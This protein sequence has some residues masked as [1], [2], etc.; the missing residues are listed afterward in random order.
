L[1]ARTS[2]VPKNPEYEH[3]IPKAFVD[4]FKNWRCQYQKDS[5]SW[6]PRRL[7][8]RLV[9]NDLPRDFSGRE[10]QTF[11]VEV[12]PLIGIIHGSATR[13][14][15]VPALAGVNAQPNTHKLTT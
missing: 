5:A 4:L 7:S 9:R 8:G 15:T 10:R 6:R 11:A 12:Q 1:K 13:S 14:R 2:S 3:V